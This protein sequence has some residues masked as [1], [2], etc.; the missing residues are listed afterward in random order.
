MSGAPLDVVTRFLDAWDGEGPTALPGTQ[1]IAEWY[2]VADGTIDRIR[3]YF[4][5]RPCASLFEQG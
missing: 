3:V 4:D 1:P 2:H 5:G